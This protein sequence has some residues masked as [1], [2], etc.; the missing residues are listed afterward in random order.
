MVD[1]RQLRQFVAVAEELHFHRA[2]AR[3]HMSQPPLTAAIR[4][5]EEHIGSALIERGNRTLGLTAAGAVLLA[6]ARLTLQQADHALAATRDAA[7]GRTGSVRL[8]Y[9]GSAL[10]GRLPQVIRAFRGSHPQVRLELIEAT[11]SAQVTMLREQRLDVGVVIPPVV[12]AGDMHLQAFDVDHLAIALPR[13]HR[14]A[15]RAPVT[16][17][18]LAGEPF[19]LWPAREGQGFHAQVMR[20]CAVAGVVPRVV[21]EA[22]GMHAVLSLVA[23]EAGIAIVP[24]SMQGFRSDEIVYQPLQGEDSGFALQLCTRHGPITP[25]L[26]QFLHTAVAPA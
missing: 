24:A 2:A 14:L 17:S 10:Y 3:L 22:H 1:L 26:Q 12:D 6:E 9:V 8:G 5:L 16:L 11:S 15:Q 13:A 19:V 4:K 20:L 18:A 21:Q 7:T 25:A 23:V